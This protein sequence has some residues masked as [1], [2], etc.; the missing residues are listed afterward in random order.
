MM[1]V[2]IAR[3]LIVDHRQDYNRDRLPWLPSR[4]YRLWREVAPTGRQK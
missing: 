4:L 1:N 2:H 3:C